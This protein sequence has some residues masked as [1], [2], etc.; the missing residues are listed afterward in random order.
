MRREEVPLPLA[1][2]SKEKLNQICESQQCSDGVKNNRCCQELRV[3]ESTALPPY[4]ES[5]KFFGV[6]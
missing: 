5:R 6:A 1:R 3:S 4:S 2:E